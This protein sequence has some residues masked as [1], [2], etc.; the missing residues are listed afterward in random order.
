[1]DTM[2]QHLWP[3]EHGTAG[4]D[5]A[6]AAAMQGRIRAGSGAGAAVSAGASRIQ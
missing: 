4:P 5:T 2:H 6:A 1:M 3:A